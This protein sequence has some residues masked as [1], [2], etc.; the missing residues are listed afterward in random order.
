MPRIESMQEIAL[1]IEPGFVGVKLAE[2]AN[3]K[4]R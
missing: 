1:S 2:G 3:Q 4:G